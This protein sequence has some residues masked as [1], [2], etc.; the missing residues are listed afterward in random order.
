MIRALRPTDLPRLARFLRRSSTGE[1]TA[2]TWPKVQ[3]E[4]GHLPVQQM[5]WHGLGQGPAHGRAWM[6]EVDGAIVGLVAGR[7]RC[8][9]LVWDVEHLHVL[10]GAP[11]HA[12]GLL[13]RLCQE[14]AAGGAR[15]VF[16][17]APV[18]APGSDVARHA[19]FERYTS[20][21]VYRLTPPF[22]VGQQEHL[23]GRP[24]LRADEQALFQLYNAAVPAVIRSAEAMSYEE[25]SALHRG[26]KSWS[27]SLVG[28]RHQYVSEL[29]M[30]LAGWLQVVYGQKSQLLELLID[31]RYE[32]MVD[33]F[34][35]Y[36]LKQVSE[37]APVYSTVREYQ[38]TLGS[39]LERVGFGLVDH[40]DIYVRQ[41]AVR[42]AERELAT[43]KMLGG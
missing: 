42:I 20:S 25:W 29:G 41:L 43:A 16:F 30:G 4:S 11:D 13:D 12:E 31:P 40:N 6:A 28:D 3:P 32:S 18:G 9:G 33:R 36:G 1:I 15:R 7:A 23:D 35:G 2:H 5:V 38:A 22:S 26:R 24:R 39:G 37:K 10:D 19:G 21:T 17:E 14:A 34:I 8:R 27:P